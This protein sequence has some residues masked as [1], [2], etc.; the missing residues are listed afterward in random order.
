MLRKSNSTVTHFYLEPHQIN[1][2]QCDFSGAEADHIVKVMRHDVG[3]V[4]KAIDGTGCLYDILITGIEKRSVTGKIMAVEKMVNELPVKITVAFGLLPMAK[5]TEIIDHCTELGVSAIQP[6]SCGNSVVESDSE[7]QERKRLRW[8]KVA[9][10]AMKQSLR[11]VLPDIVAPISIEQLCGRVASFDL[12]L[13]ASFHGGAFPEGRQIQTH[14]SIL[15]IT[16]SEAG[17]TSDEEGA[18]IEAGAQ[19]VSLGTRRLR[20][21][22]APV[23]MTT[24]LIA[25]LRLE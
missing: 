6:L 14:K 13:L 3:D 18:L 1:G 15:L 22:L 21:E 24:S 17:F 19:P 11:S 10:A 23:A 12:A 7:R 4:V 8:Q 20:A 2:S 5:T 9:I 25:G 16:G